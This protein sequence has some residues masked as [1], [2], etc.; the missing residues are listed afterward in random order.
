MAKESNQMFWQFV[1]SVLLEESDKFKECTVNF[2]LVFHFLLFSKIR[3]RFLKI[4]INKY[5]I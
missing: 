4:R 5:T 1:D 3:D 2:F